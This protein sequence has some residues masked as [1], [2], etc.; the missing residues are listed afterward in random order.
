MPTMLTYPFPLRPQEMTI[1]Q[2][3]K[4]RNYTLGDMTPEEEENFYNEL[5]EYKKNRELEEDKKNR[6]RGRD[7]SDTQLLDEEEMEI[8]KASKVF[9]EDEAP[10][11]PIG[12]KEKEMYGNMDVDYD[13]FL[14]ELDYENEGGKRRN[15]TRKGGRRHKRRTTKKYQK[16]RKSQKQKKMHKKDRTHGKRRV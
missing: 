1:A 2:L 12:K 10:K 6:K 15:K 3:E 7:S 14:K 8:L 16:K 4:F 9:E 11:T 13:D 5:A